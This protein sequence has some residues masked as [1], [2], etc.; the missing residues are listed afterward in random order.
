MLGHGAHQVAAQ[1]D[2]GL[3]LAVAD[4]FA[5]FDGV[6]ALVAR[7]FEAVLFLQ[8]VERRQ[9]RFFRDA[10]RALALHVGVAAHRADAGARLADVPAQQEKVHQHLHV[11]HAVAVLGQAHAVDADHGIRRHVD[12]RG[13]AQIGAVEAGFLLDLVPGGGDDLVG[14]KAPRPCV[15]SAMKAV[16]SAGGSPRLCAASSSSRTAL[17]RPIRAAMSPPPSVDGTGC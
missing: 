10:D 4:A 17:H 12:A 8:L 11:L 16:S 9:L 7:R 15:C 2:E 13:V 6:H 5:G 14:L 3:D 1:A